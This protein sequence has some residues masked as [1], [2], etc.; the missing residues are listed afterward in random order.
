M[1]ADLHTPSFIG[2]RA[3]VLHRPHQNVDALLAQ[4]ARLGIRGEQAWP[5]FPRDRAPDD[6]NVVLIDAD[7]GHDGQLPWKEGEAPVPIIALIGAEAPG[8]I[9][10][11]IAQGADAQ[12][13]KPIGSA[14]LY[15]AITMACHAFARRRALAD[16]IAGLKQRLG[17]RQQLAEATALLMLK[18]NCTAE[19]AYQQLRV[20]AMAQRSTIEEAA[21]AVVEE[22]ETHGFRNVDGGR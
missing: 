7:M 18:K 3:I 5:D 13:L 21:A 6:C 19:E 9:A 2:W 11:S 16:E 20:L 15:S 22:F 14:G 12:L 1:S 8:R 4:C 10:W 17:R